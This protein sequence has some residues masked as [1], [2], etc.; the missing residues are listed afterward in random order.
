MAIMIR[1]ASYRSVLP[2]ALAAMML[3][4]SPAA[5]DVYGLAVVSQGDSL[6]VG[7][8]R[9]RLY[10]I[11]APPVTMK[12]SINGEPWDCGRESRD[13]LA[14]LVEGQRLRCIEEGRDRW[15]RVL[16]TCFLP[17]GQDVGAELI[18]QGFAV[19]FTSVTDRYVHVEERAR[20]DHRG[21]WAGTFPPPWQWTDNPKSFK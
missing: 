17:S 8:R 4:A 7:S 14:K 5:A 1:S 20:M 13:L 18:R 11:D 12:C 15:G 16:A 2:A 6:T 3:Y 21:I 9:V 19:A 10:G